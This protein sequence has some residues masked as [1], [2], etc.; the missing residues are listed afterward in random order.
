MFSNLAHVLFGGAEPVETRAEPDPPATLDWGISVKSPLLKRLFDLWRGKR[1]GARIPRRADFDPLEMRDLLGSLLIVRSLPEIYDFRFT[2]MGTH[3]VD[4]SG[5]ETTGHLVTETFEDQAVELFRFLRDRAQPVRVHG[6][7]Y[8]RN[9]DYKGF[10]VVL[11]PFA[12]E[13]GAVDGF[14][15]AMDFSLGDG[16]DLAC[17][18]AP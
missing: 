10:E 12:G 11:L 6:Q 8:W 5:R 15:G 2:L 4:E 17:C 7:F 3:I 9:Q 18:V 14:I 16:E 13:D 1:H